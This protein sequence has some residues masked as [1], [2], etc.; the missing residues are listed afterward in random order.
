MCFVRIHLVHVTL[1]SNT[2][3]GNARSKVVLDQ[4]IFRLQVSEKKL[5]KREKK[6]NQNYRWTITPLF[7]VLSKSVSELYAG[8]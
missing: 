8:Q 1:H 3:I 7:G 4:N 6:Q 5:L 2:K